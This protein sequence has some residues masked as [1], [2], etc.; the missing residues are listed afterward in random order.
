MSAGLQRRRDFLADTKNH[1]VNLLQTSRR[2]LQEVESQRCSRARE[3]AE[4]RRAEMQAFRDRCAS[5]RDKVL[6]DLQTMADEYRAASQAWKQRH[7]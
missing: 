1:V 6:S 5:E 4:A 7:I 2:D 3:A